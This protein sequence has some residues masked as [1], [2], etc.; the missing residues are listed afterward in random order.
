M[1]LI[2]TYLVLPLLFFVSIVYQSKHVEGTNKKTKKQNKKQKQKKENRGKESVSAT[3]GI[4][5]TLSISYPFKMVFV[6]FSLN[7][8]S[9]LHVF[10]S[11]PQL[12]HR[13][14]PF[15]DMQ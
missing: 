8:R 10:I 1:K 5:V 13:L 7:L 6:K 2:K 3:Q 15:T 12:F 14:T 4:H 11:S 9:D